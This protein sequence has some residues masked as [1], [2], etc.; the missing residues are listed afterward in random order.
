MNFKQLLF[1]KR[2]ITNFKDNLL[3]KSYILPKKI[4]NTLKKLLEEEY[5]KKRDKIP[6]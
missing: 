6:S 5:V 3:T 4:N 1:T 2:I